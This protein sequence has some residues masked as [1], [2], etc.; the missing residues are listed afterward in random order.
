[1]L[2]HALNMGWGLVVLLGFVCLGRIMARL[3]H[4]NGE[5]DVAMAAGWG[6]AGMVALGGWMTLLGLARPPFVIVLVVAVIVLDLVYEGRR[7]F[8]SEPRPP[9]VPRE[10]TGRASWL[11]LAV[12]VG[13]IA[14][15]YAASVVNFIQL[16]HDPVAYLLELARMVQTGSPGPDPFSE[17][18]MLA[19][20]GQ[21]FLMG[22]VGSVAPYH[23]AF[24]LDPGVCWIMIAGLVWFFVRRD[25][26]RSVRD[27]S[28]AAGL[29]V[30]LRIPELCNLGG[31]MTGTVLF[32]TLLRTACW[33]CRE[34][35][36]LNLGA[37]LLLACTAAALCAIR[38]TFLTYTAMF[39]AFWYASRL[40]QSPRVVIVREMCLVG[41]VALALLVP[42]MWQQYR[43]CGTPLYPLLG[44]GYHAHN[45]GRAL[46]GESPKFKA[47]SVAVF[48]FELPTVPLVLALLIMVCD[49]W[50]DR[51]RW[52]L[53]VAAAFSAM[54]TSLFFAFQIADYATVRSVYPVHYAIL[55]LV[56]LYGFFRRRPGTAGAG[57][58]VCLAIFL[59]TKWDNLRLLERMP[60]FLAASE[61]WLAVKPPPPKIR[62][63]QATI[64]PGKQTL[65]SIQD[66]YLIDFAAIRSGAWTTLR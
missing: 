56:G 59:G 63:A 3:A 22:L 18:L 34:K 4:P 20:N 9:V 58:A 8:L 42:W 26:G 21:V 37:T 50:D 47:F 16:D 6:M 28:I 31:N 48:L 19:L 65:A 52:R 66:G 12:L 53:F 64:P 25:L 62:E 51:C 54:I 10:P 29:V 5:W 14:V 61:G 60:G 49:R 24:L 30:M 38:T 41:L 40:W 33:G 15:K 43:S 55:I 1:M 32:L 27:A 46:F 17:R 36:H 45:T 39:L 35:G 2:A 23:Y 11:W 7:F 13:V 44:N 57:L